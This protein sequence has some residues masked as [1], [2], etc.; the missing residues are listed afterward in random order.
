MACIGIKTE[1]IRLLEGKVD[2]QNHI[3]AEVV[4]KLFLGRL[5]S[6]VIKTETGKMLHVKIPSSAG[7]AISKGME[8]TAHLIPSQCIVFPIPEEGLRKELEV[9]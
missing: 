3:P 6:V 8:V 5:V 2:G 7:S 9:E 4:R 1:N